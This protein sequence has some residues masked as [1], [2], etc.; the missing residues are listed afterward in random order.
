M[1]IKLNKQLVLNNIQNKLDEIINL[2]EILF[3]N[4]ESGF[5]EVETARIV[6][7]K[8][9]PLG[10]LLN[11]NDINFIELHDIPGLKL[12]VDTGI[13][14]PSVAI[15]AELDAIICPLH[16]DSNKNTGA[17]HA[18]GHN[19]QLT[20]MVGAAIGLIDESVLK[21]LSGKIH[22]IAVPAEE[23]IEL[24][25]REEL[26][27]KGLIKYMAGKP[28]FL[29]RGLFDDVD[30][31][32]TIHTFVNK[33]K[34]AINKSFNGCL[35]KKVEYKGKAT[36]AASPYN[37]V[38]ALYAANLGMAGINSIRETF[39]EEDYIRV[40]PIIT[41]GGDIVNVIPDDVRVETFVRAKTLKGIEETNKKV[42]RAFVAGAL[43][44]G[45][46]IKITDYPGYLPLTTDENLNELSMEVLS[47]LV[48]PDDITVV[49]HATGS[50]DLGDL[51]SLMPVSLTLI[52]GVEGGLHTADYKVID[53]ETAFVLGAKVV[54]LMTVELLSNNGKKAIDILGK[55]IPEFK[56]KED[57][58]SYVDKMSCEKTFD[59]ICECLF[60]Q[61]VND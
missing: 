20:S 12:T 10:N 39:L 11:Q 35:L 15:L 30:M 27:K 53:P 33:K 52:G 7:E 25:Y 29:H 8:M 23:L 47:G 32:L 22:F 38:N 54:A 42:D 1:D 9:R 45:A 55:F 61:S 5:K 56:S 2:G 37:S 24:S 40:H 44:L 16:P 50:T 26:Q 13:P 43:A 14:G 19:S 6:A 36:H 28:E 46:Q 34:I 59:N 60:M 21:Q 57:Y 17:V 48:I 31:C 51:S 3:K 41:K 49:S 4:P 58:F 18:C